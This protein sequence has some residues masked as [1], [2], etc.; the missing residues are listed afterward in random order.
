MV[1]KN[2]SHMIALCSDD[3]KVITN[4]HQK[5][6]DGVIKKEMLISHTPSSL[7]PET[8]FAAYPKKPAVVDFQEG[9]QMP[10]WCWRVML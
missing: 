10:K 9:K 5:V 2:I 6:Q 7:R 4:G 1:Y 8:T 3:L